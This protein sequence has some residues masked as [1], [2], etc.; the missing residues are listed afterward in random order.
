LLAQARRNLLQVYTAEIKSHDITDIS[1]PFLFHILPIIF[2]DYIII[3]FRFEIDELAAMY[4]PKHLSEKN[5]PCAN[6]NT[7][8][9]LNIYGTFKLLIPMFPFNSINNDSDED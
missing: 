8:C 9:I 2:P 3:V 5:L 6:S 4:Y 7:I 1:I